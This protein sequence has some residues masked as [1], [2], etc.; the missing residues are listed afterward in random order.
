[1]KKRFIHSLSLLIMGGLLLGLP[2]SLLSAERCEEVVKNL[3]Q[4][5]HPKIDEKELFV[6]LKVL[7]ETDNQ[8]LPPNSSPRTRPGSWAGTRGRTCGV[9]T[10][11]RERASAGMSS[12]TGKE[13]SPTGKGGG[14][15]PTWI[16]GAGA[17]GRNAL[18]IPTTV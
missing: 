5:L 18:S 6:V 12:A 3:N 13:S 17:G 2:A 10:G 8:K 4:A 9:T 1:M 15:R 16:T 7:N 11:S 14:A